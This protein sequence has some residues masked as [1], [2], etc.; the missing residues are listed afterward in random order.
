[1]APTRPITT[2]STQSRSES[3]CAHTSAFRCVCA[4]VGVC[5]CVCV[6]ACARVCVC[7]CVVSLGIVA[8]C[9]VCFGAWVLSFLHDEECTAQA[10]CWP[11][12]GSTSAAT[13]TMA[14]SRRLTACWLL[15]IDRRGRRDSLHPMLSVDSATGVRCHGFRCCREAGKKVA[16]SASGTHRLTQSCARAV[17]HLRC[18][19]H[20]DGGIHRLDA[21]YDRWSQP[22]C[23]LAVTRCTRALCATDRWTDLCCLPRVGT[24]DAVVLGC[25]RRPIQ[26][27]SD[28]PRVGRVEPKGIID[29]GRHESSGYRLVLHMLMANHNTA[30][31]STCVLEPCHTYQT[32]SRRLAPFLVSNSCVD[33]VFAE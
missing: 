3:S 12:A 7:V 30:G 23:V 32:T 29:L 11:F 22:L 25:V 9:R 21:P 18:V 13:Q 4:C 15:P 5:A 16:A 31:P 19:N 27:C 24:R 17:E 8:V 20:N 1:M 28:L 26:V 6:C 10:P 33:P 2:I 14:L